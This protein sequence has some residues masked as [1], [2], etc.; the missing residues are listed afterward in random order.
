MTIG[1]IVR[2]ALRIAL[3]ERWLWLFGFFVGIWSG[4]S[5]GGSGGSDSIAAGMAGAPL[6][7]SQG[8]A[9]GDGILRLPLGIVALIG[10]GLVVGLAL[11][12]MRFLSEGA[13]I[14]GVVRAREGRTMMVRTGLSTGRAHWGVLLRLGLL[15]AAVAFVSVGVPVAIVAALVQTA[16]VIPGVLVALLLA[17]PLVPWL[18]TIYMVQAFA[19]RI[20]VLE[21]RTARDAIAKARLFLHG[22]LTLGLK[23]LLAAF[24]GSTLVGIA[25]MLVILPIVLLGFGLMYVLPVALVIAICGVVVAPVVVVSSSVLGTYRSSVWTLGYLSQVRV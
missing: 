21:E 8:G 17:I 7:L 18:V 5:G 19:M 24:I 22:R 2:Q 12:V 13:L 4:G 3:T 10:I 16:G 11:L 6:A 1:D 20:A 15:Y 25:A 9:V 23:L 14:V